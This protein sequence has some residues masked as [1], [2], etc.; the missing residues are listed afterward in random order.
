M[1]LTKY[2]L[3]TAIALSAAGCTTSTTYAPKDITKLDS[4]NVKALNA[5]AQKPL[6]V[7]FE[8]DSRIDPTN[9][10]FRQPDYQ[11]SLEDARNLVSTYGN[12]PPVNAL[13]YV[14][15]SNSTGQV[16]PYLL[17]TTGPLNKA[18]PVIRELETLLNLPNSQRTRLIEGNPDVNF[19]SSETSNRQSSSNSGLLGVDYFWTN[20]DASNFVISV[21]EVSGVDSSFDVRHNY[22]ISI[23]FGEPTYSESKLRKDKAFPVKVA[24]DAVVNIPFGSP[25]GAVLN[26]FIDGG[27][28]FIE[29]K[30]PLGTSLESGRIHISRLTQKQSDLVSLLRNASSTKTTN[31]IT[32][33]FGDSVAVV[34]ARNARNV[35]ADDH[36]IT[37]ET[38]RESAMGIGRFIY[39]AA[40]NAAITATVSNDSNS[41]TNTKTITKTRTIFRDR[42][43]PPTG[44]ISGGES[45]GAG[46]Q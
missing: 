39:G 23:Q 13:V 30:A 18:V 12:L 17:N 38:D 37:F 28:A 1:S 20:S 42:P 14:P 44:N 11:A 9:V 7:S 45:G 19:L 3:G 40:K 2:L 29:S 41:K 21:K 34:Y 33:N 25:L 36:V 43:T 16:D 35:V 26:D 8:P 27:Y 10:N 5:K 15:Q 24:G 6:D 32:A 4:L 46:G 22:K 31:I